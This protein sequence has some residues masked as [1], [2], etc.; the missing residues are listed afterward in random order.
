[1]GKTSQEGHDREGKQESKQ[2]PLPIKSTRMQTALDS[3]KRQIKINTQS[4][5][6]KHKEEKTTRKLISQ[7]GERNDHARGNEKQWKNRVWNLKREAMGVLEL[8]KIR[9]FLSSQII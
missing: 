2:P 1:M 9:L 8:S 6:P 7:S 3:S 5:H 4:A